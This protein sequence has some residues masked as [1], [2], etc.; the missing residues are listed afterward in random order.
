[1]C[2]HSFVSASVAIAT[3]RL[4]SGSSVTQSM[5]RRPVTDDVQ[6]VSLAPGTSTVSECVQPS[7]GGD[8]LSAEASSL[9][10]R[11]AERK[12][13]DIR[14]EEIKKGSG[15]EEEAFLCVDCQARERRRRL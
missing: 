4:H 12:E 15:P 11:A 2:D 5:A 10:S 14:G 8:A 1:M 7:K 3:C 13:E 6:V 9:R